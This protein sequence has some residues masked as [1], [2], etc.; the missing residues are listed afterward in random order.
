[1]KACSMWFDFVGLS[2]QQVGGKKQNPNRFGSVES[3]PLKT[4]EGGAAFARIQ[5]GKIK[6]QG[7]PV[8]VANNESSFI[9]SSKHFGSA[10]SC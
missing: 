8:P 3:H 2:R 10:A 6:N 5:K 9:E 7:W 4:A 1:M